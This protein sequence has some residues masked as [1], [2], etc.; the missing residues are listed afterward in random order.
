MILSPFI[1]KPAQ[2][3]RVRNYQSIPLR[4][5][6]EL[7]KMPGVYYCL[8]GWK[9]LYIGKSTNIHARWNSYQFGPHHKLDELIQIND[10]IGDIDLHYCE[11]SEPLIGFIEAVEIGRFKPPMNKRY[12][13][14]WDN[15]NLPVIGFVL[16]SL[17]SQ[18][19][20]ALLS[21]AVIWLLLY[22]LVFAG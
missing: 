7:P 4:D 10:S 12:E 11:W 6:W 9:V 18:I 16:K 22:H 20:M 2:L 15:V 19:L 14:V 5:K 1:P 13:R 3:L 17:G 21:S 8:R